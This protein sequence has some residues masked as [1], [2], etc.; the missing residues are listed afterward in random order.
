MG[1]YLYFKVF[2]KKKNLMQIRE[3]YLGTIL[4]EHFGKF[5]YIFILLSLMFSI[6]LENTLMLD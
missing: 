4:F 5:P 6:T 3:Y 2:L 1:Q